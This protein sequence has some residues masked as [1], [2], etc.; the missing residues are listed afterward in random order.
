MNNDLELLREIVE[1]FERGRD[2]SWNEVETAFG[3]V[4]KLLLD[5]NEGAP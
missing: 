4:R 2:I 1:D 5:K 3:I